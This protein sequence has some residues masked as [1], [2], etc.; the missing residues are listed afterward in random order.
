MSSQ[1]SDQA[2]RVGVWIR[3]STEDQARGDS[4]EHHERRACA[5]AEVKG[6]TVVETYRLEA[7]SGKAVMHTRRHLIGVSAF[8]GSGRNRP[9]FRRS[10]GCE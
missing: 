3:V 8:D 1:P 4:P 6:W 7:V 9:T 10:F 2:K 5:Y